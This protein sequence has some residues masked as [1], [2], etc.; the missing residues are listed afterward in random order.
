LPLGFACAV[1]PR[2]ELAFHH[3]EKHSPAFFVAGTGFSP[4]YLVLHAP[5]FLVGVGL[6]PIRDLRVDGADYLFHALVRAYFDLVAPSA[7]LA[8]ENLPGERAQELFPEVPPEQRLEAYHDAVASFVAH[9]LSV[10]VELERKQAEWSAE[11]RSLCPDGGAGGPLFAL[12]EHIFLDQPYHGR[13]FRTAAPGGGGGRETL[14]SR[15]ALGLEDKE[16]WAG[17]L[18]GSAWTGRASPDFGHFCAPE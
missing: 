11:G 15:R 13:Y 2:L 12:W 14:Y 1:A 18:L 4:P 6:R 3:Q 10:A 16:L 9:A 8:P 17:E 7:S 5:S